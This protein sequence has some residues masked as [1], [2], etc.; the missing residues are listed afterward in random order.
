MLGDGE[1]FVGEFQN[2]LHLP[3]LYAGEP[4]EELADGGAA[5]E[6][7]E[8]RPHRDARAAKQPRPADLAGRAF[9]FRALI[10]I[11]QSV[12]SRR[13]VDGASRAISG[14]PRLAV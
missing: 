10:P 6:I 14:R 9:S 5:F 12:S 3:A 4:F 13:K 11:G 1:A 2:R 8:E 7:L